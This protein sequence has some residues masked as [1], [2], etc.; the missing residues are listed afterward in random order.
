MKKLD[1]KLLMAVRV[2]DYLL[3]AP[4]RA[5]KP[6]LYLINNFSMVA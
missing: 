4:V 2:Y 6:L 1:Y 5:G 3:R